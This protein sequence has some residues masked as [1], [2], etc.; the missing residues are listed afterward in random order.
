MLGGPGAVGVTE[1]V[2]GGPGGVGAWLRGA[3]VF[4][5]CVV[6]RL[7]GSVALPRGVAI[8]RGEAAAEPWDVGLVAPS[9]CSVVPG[10]E[11]RRGWGRV[12]GGVTEL[13]LGGPG[14]GS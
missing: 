1:L 5:G 2:L 12:C 8:P 13:V 14:I 4:V 11:G 3:V 10:V 7:R 6:V 9:W